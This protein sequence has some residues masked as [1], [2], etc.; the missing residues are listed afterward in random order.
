MDSYKKEMYE[1]YYLRHGY[2]PESLS[3]AENFYA[4]RY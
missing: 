1:F 2:Y 3:E 4:D